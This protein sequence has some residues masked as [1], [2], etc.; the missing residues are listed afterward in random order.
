MCDI[1]KTLPTLTV[2]HPHCTNTNPPRTTDCPWCWVIVIKSV[3]VM[4]RTDQGLCAV[5]YDNEIK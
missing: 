4:G 1:V 2:T 5:L 3:I